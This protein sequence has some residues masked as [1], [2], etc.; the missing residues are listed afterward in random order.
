MG[1]CRLYCTAN[2]NVVVLNWFVSTSNYWL[3]LLKILDLGKPL[4]SHRPLFM[5]PYVSVRYYRPPEIIFNLEC[6]ENGEIYIHRTVIIVFMKT[7][8]LQWISGP[9]GAFLL[10]CGEVMFFCLV[11]TV[12]TNQIMCAWVCVCWLVHFL[13]TLF[14]S[15]SVEQDGPAVWYSSIWVLQEI[16]TFGK[17][18]CMSLH[19][20]VYL[21][22]LTNQI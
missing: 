1:V 21:C 4:D 16:S 13:D 17:L 11:K 8:P 20:H 18:T 3:S 22:S 7:T 2:A 9:L 5:T 15:W 12:S 14:R 10:S 6:K 19:T